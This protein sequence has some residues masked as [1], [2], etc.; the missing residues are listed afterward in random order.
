MVTTFD[1]ADYDRLL[2]AKVNNPEAQKALDDWNQKAA[3]VAALRQQQT[4]NPNPELAQT[5]LTQE[6]ELN[7][8]AEA[9]ANQYIEIADLF[10]TR[11]SDIARLQ[12][13]I[14]A[15]TVVIQSAPLQ[16]E[17][18]SEAENRG[19]ALFAVTQDS[20][21]VVQTDLPADFNEQ[22]STYRD[23]L[24]GA[25]PYIRNSA[26][27]YDRLIRPLEDQNLIPPGS[28]LAIIATGKLREIPFETLFDQESEQFLLE[29]YSFHYLTRL[30]K[31]VPEQL[32]SRQQI[33]PLVIANPLPSQSPLEGTEAEAQQIASLYPSAQIYKNRN[34]TLDDF[35]QKALNADLIHL[36]T[37]GCFNPDGCPALGMPPNTLLFANN[38]TYPLADAALLGLNN[39]ELLVLGACETARITPDND[40]DLTGLAY[41]WERA[42]AK[43]ILASLWSTPDKDSAT[44]MA[45]FYQN[46][47]DGMGKAEALRQ[48]KLQLVAKHPFNW[49]PFILIGDGMGTVGQ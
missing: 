33:Q 12:Q 15:N 30:S 6:A 9:I 31:T 11:P 29:K 25:K 18:E 49:S 41:I 47:N 16:Y 22:L 43:T 5:I 14:P 20:I 34:A 7:Q 27:L 1:L 10:E 45:A 21:N 19:I 40:F 44:I 26:A 32:Q 3:A 39:T 35:K 48:A 38:Q 42:G 36:G 37:H 46:L 28:T 23:Q 24:A 2:E 4:N 17:K 8:Q 13:T